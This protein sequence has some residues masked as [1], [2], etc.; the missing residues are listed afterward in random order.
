MHFEFVMLID[1][2]LT[3]TGVMCGSYFGN[4]AYLSRMCNYPNCFDNNDGNVYPVCSY[5][6]LRRGEINTYLGLFGLIIITNF[7]FSD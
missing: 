5:F 2:Y 7:I 3:F 4:A 1:P 6:H